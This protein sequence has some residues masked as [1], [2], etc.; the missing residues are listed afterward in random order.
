MLEE[1]DVN[2][3]EISEE[4][5]TEEEQEIENEEQ[6]Q[7]SDT[8]PYE[9][10]AEVNNQFRET[11]A[12]LA[13]ARE[14]LEALEEEPEEEPEFKTPEDLI[15]YQDKKVDEKLNST[16]E[17]RDAAME[18]KLEA[19]NQ[20]MQLEKEYPDAIQ[21]PM[22]TD[23]VAAKISANPDINLLEAANEATKY[24]DSIK[25]EGKKEAEE[26]LQTR[27]TFQGK[28]IGGQPEQSDAD[29]DYAQSIV[30]AGGGNGI[31]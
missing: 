11:E 25:E 4:S 1:N 3:E 18:S 31:F 2:E 15:A 16:L 7:E 22:F 20:M 26:L 29:K 21:D 23:I 12:E 17:A 14:Q 28:V 13:I 9:R 6:T 27:G 19:Q 5:S 30:E 8:V 24:M 10:F